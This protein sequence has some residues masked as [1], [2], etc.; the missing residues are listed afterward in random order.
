MAAD[1]KVYA[2]TTCVHCKHAKEF[3]DEQHIPYDCVHVDYLTG[4]ERTKVMEIVRKLNPSLSFPTIVIGDKV[5]VGFRREEL[6]T[7]LA[8]CHK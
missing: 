6:Q 4:E 1:I 5:I 3:L 2:L 7:L 8:G